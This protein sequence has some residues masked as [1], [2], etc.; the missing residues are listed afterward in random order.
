MPNSLIRNEEF[1]KW[2]AIAGPNLGLCTL[3]TCRTRCIQQ[4][5]R[6]QCREHQIVACM[7]CRHTHPSSESQSTVERS[8]RLSLN[9]FCGLVEVEGVERVLWICEPVVPQADA[10]VYKPS[11]PSKEGTKQFLIYSLTEQLLTVDLYDENPYV[12][13]RSVRIS[14][15]R[16]RTSVGVIVRERVGF[17]E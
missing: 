1:A 10:R 9:P 13:A 2:F 12:E 11:C 16:P 6:T 4:S 7:G 15:S 5:S 14:K 17:G 8:R 3:V